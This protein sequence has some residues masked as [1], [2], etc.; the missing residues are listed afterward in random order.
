MKV[1]FV[2][3]RHSHIAGLYKRMK[4]DSRY[5]IV[6]ACEE[7]AAAREEAAR[8]FGATITH[9]DFATMLAEVDFDILAIGDYFGIRG[10]RAIAAL[11]AGKHVVADKPLCTSLDEL[12]E[13][14]ALATANKL[15][16]GLMLDFR[17]HG[18]VEAAKAIIDSGRLG[19]IHAIQFGGQHPLNYGSRPAWYFEDGKHGGTINDIAIH[20]LDAVEY[21]TGR[22]TDQLLAARMWNAFATKEPHFKD[23]AQFMYTL[24]NKCGVM[25]DVTY[26]QPRFDSPLYWRFTF[27]GEAGVMEFNH[28]DAGVKLCMK[29]GEGVEVVPQVAGKSDYL[30]IFENELAGAKEP[31]GTEHILEVTAAALRLQQ[32]AM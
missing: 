11:K 6:A 7:D 20:G 12:N 21:I 23:A 25:A 32:I 31:F 4:D 2:G 19:T 1:A 22:K 30:T 16:V 14:R 8:I 10:Q 29:E 24:D 13:I 15:V 9:T 27:W 28:N 5:E 3:F 26:A 17:F 18:N